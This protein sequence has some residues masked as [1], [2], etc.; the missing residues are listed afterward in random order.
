[1]KAEEEK[2]FD[3]MKGPKFCEKSSL[4]KPSIQNNICQVLHNKMQDT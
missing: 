3:A 4:A 1:M 2:T